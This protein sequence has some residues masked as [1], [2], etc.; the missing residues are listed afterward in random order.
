MSEPKLAEE[1][2]KIPH[3]PLLPIEKRLIA[4]SLLLGAGLLG[5]PLWVSNTWFAV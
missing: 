1:L 2:A 4:Y 3:E 5:I